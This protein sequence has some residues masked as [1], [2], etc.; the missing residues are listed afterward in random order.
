MGRSQE[1]FSKKEKEK[2]RDKK[3]QD[4]EKKKEVRK[5]NLTKGQSLDTMLA[6]VDENGN[7]THTPP[8]LQRRKEIAIEDI[9]IQVSRQ[10]N[11]PDRANREG[12]ISSYTESKGYGFIKE[13]HAHQTIFFH[14]SGLIDQIRLNDVVSFQV[15]TTPKGLSAIDIRKLR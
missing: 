3:R 2:A 14:K 4:K 13:A 8:D 12:I 9:V 11:A 15:E 7:L 6:Y 1:T 10:E 5:A